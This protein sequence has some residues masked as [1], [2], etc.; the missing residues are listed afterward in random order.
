MSEPQIIVADDWT[1]NWQANIAV[2]ITAMVLWVVIVVTFAVLVGVIWKYENELRK[3][4][5]TQAE[6]LQDEIN[7][8]LHY[9]KNINLEKL[10]RRLERE[11]EHRSLQAIELSMDGNSYLLGKV[12]ELAETVI[13]ELA[14]PDVITG[15]G[16]MTGQLIAYHEP[17]RTT[18]IKES[19]NLVIGVVLA[20]IAFGLFLTWIIHTVLSKPFQ[21]LINATRSVSDGDLDTRINFTRQDEFGHLSRFFNEM[22]NKISEQ[23]Q[24][25]LKANDE[26]KNEISVR[27]NAEQLLLAHSDHLEKIVNERTTDLAVARDQALQASQTKSAFIANMSHEVRTPLTAIIGFGESILEGNHSETE[28]LEAVRTVIRNGRHLLTIINDILDMSKME[29]GKLDVERIRMSPFLLLTDIESLVGMQA[30]DKGLDFTIQYAFPLP[31]MITSDPTRLKQILLNL[32]ANAVKFT[33]QGSVR[34]TVSCKVVTRQMTFAVVDS[35]IGMSAAAQERLFMAFSQADSSTTRKFGGTGLGLFISKRLAQM[36]GGDITVESVEGLGSKFTVSVDTGTL[37]EVQFIE[38]FDAL[39][40]TEKLAVT[41]RENMALEGRVLVAEDSIDNQRLISMYLRRAGNI[42][43]TLVTNGKLA[44]EQ[45]LAGDFD[46]LLMDMQMPVMGG[47]E[48]VRLLRTAGYSRP[49]IALTANAMKEDQESYIAVGCNAFLS[50]PIDQQQFFSVLAQQLGA[51]AAA[52]R[53]CMADLEG[54]EFAKLVQR[55]VEGLPEYRLQLDA[56]IFTKQWDQAKSVVHSLK[57]MGG[58]FGYPSITQLSGL[59]EAALLQHDMD[60]LSGHHV[61]LINEIERICSQT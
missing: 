61:N 45:A 53:A 11:L 50:K 5:P 14:L 47:L 44:V 30:R 60:N 52:Q 8:F 26:L 31:E 4:F 46:L 38:R 2:K 49:I 7:T 15:N 20:I 12:P 54:D 22:L 43:C 36:L 37:D 10:T 40:C 23:Q 33:A 35:G 59:L 42:D 6:N 19:R 32:C 16:A 1:R 57:G 39:R 17:F 28:K 58:S 3:S 13:V 18:A 21:V 56:A 34:V 29:A 51:V 24:A 55:F 41:Q 25:L 9:E 27:M 48:A